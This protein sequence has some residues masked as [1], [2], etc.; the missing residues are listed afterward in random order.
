MR[1]KTE[2]RSERPSDDEIAQIAYELWE[3]YGR[4]HGRD[5]EHW[6]EAEAILRTPGTFDVTLADPGDN[7]VQVI[8]TIRD[9]TG[10]D[11]NAAW[12][13]LSAAPRTLGMALPRADAEALV[14]AL[15]KA[16]ANARLTRR[17]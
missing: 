11:L 7:E 17:I 9:V 13:L 10:L 12:T 15:R 16:G 14:A 5:V 2:D 3:Q 8:R 4:I 6:L 1:E